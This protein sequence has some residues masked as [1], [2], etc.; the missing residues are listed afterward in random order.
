MTRP[1]KQEPKDRE[2]EVYGQRHSEVGRL[3][4]DL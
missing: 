1:E 3:R 4:E 2:R